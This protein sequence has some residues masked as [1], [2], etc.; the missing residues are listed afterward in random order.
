MVD[1][2]YFHHDLSHDQLEDHHIAAANNSDTAHFHT[3]SADFDQSHNQIADPAH[4]HN[5]GTDHHSC[6]F[7][8]TKDIVFRSYYCRNYLHSYYYQNYLLVLHLHLFPFLHHHLYHLDHL[9]LLSLHHVH[10]HVIDHHRFV[11]LMKV[12]KWSEWNLL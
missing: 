2:C 9:D 5:P 6:L 3:C 7:A 11:D 1:I 10:H 8:R 4:I 12:L